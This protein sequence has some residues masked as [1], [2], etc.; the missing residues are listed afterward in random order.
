MISIAQ[1]ISV[2]N[3]DGDKI[4][5]NFINEGT[6][7]E[8]T[9]NGY[10]YYSGNVNIPD[11]VI[12]NGVTYP[13]TSIGNEA[14]THSNALLTV[15]IP[16]SVT[17]I[18]KQSFSY[19]PNLSSVII[20]NKVTIIEDK[21]F[22][23]CSNLKCITMGNSVKV[24]GTSA[25]EYCGL[26]KVIIKDITA[27]FNILFYN[28]SSNPLY[29]SGHIY[30]DDDTEITE[31]IIPEGVTKINDFAFYNCKGLES[32]T[33]TNSVESIGCSAFQNCYNLTSIISPNNVYSFNLEAFIDSDSFNPYGGNQNIAI[34]PNSVTW[35]QESAFNGCW[36]LT[37]L[38]IPNSVESIGDKA[39]QGCF[40]SNVISMME[41]PPSI[42]GPSR[43]PYYYSPFDESTF[44]SAIL[45][46]PMG[47]RDEYEYNSEGWKD[48]L[49]IWELPSPEYNLK[50]IVDGNEYKTY[51]IEYG[52]TITPEPAPQK[53]GHMFSGWV[54]LPETMPAHDVTT[55]GSF[56]IPELIDG[57]EY[58]NVALIKN[59]DVTYTRA[60]NNTN[61]QAL[62]VPFS[63]SYDDW[64]DDFDV[65]EIN[66]SSFG[67]PILWV[68]N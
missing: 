47:K 51:K 59:I 68:L 7:L 43:D 52:A 45:Y 10:H 13:V 42:Y 67:S 14:F 30:I 64:R 34:I 61:W 27:W 50:Y 15:S 17:I 36:L 26:E 21:A 38:V 29:S 63:M 11:Y 65:A 18:G 55:I 24:I 23:N 16:N 62:Y 35:I 60:F 53:D 8:V 39:F 19:C 3:T 1:R 31:L 2:V 28:Q 32:I 20:P 22:Y 49:S 9:S 44:K 57:I 5:Y 37:T 6:E 46:V 66:N 12:Y 25:F 58:S 48:F 33:F 41:Q 40:L 56:I 54:G 4:F